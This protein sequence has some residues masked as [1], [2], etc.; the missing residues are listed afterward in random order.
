MLLCRCAI[1]KLLARSRIFLFSTLFPIVFFFHLRFSYCLNVKRF[2][3]LAVAVTAWPSFDTV[4]AVMWRW[5][6]FLHRTYFDVDC[7]L[8][9]SSSSCGTLCY[10]ISHWRHHW[11][12]LGNVW[13]PISSIIPSYIFGR[14]LCT[15]TAMRRW[16]RDSKMS[17][18]SAIGNWQISGYG[19][20][21]ADST[22]K[23]AASLM[24]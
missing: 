14:G 21:P 24:S 13:R 7:Y 17:N 3:A 9:G 16:T 6:I 18:V 10:R 8:F 1:K 23:F 4:F 19:S 11:L 22:V 2:A 20:L 15:L 5:H 12:P